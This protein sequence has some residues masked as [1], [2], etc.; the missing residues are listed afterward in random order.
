[1]TEL[2]QLNSRKLH[3]Q[4]MAIFFV[5]YIA[6]AVS[7]T[8]MLPFLSD[9]GY[10]SS[11]KGLIL[12]GAAVISIIGQFLFGF[13]CDKYKT[14]KK[15]FYLATIVFILIVTWAYSVTEIAF[16]FHLITLSL[17]GGF[18]RIVVGL[19]DS[20]TIERDPL[21]Q[22]NYGII[23][24]FG[25]LGWIIGAPYTVWA[26]SKGGYGSIGLNVGILSI[27]TL[28]IGATMGDAQKVSHQAPIKMVDIK[29]LLKKKQY[30]ILLI[31]L[32]LINIV[33]YADAYTIVNKILALGGTATDISNKW[34]LQAFMEL[35]LFFLGSVLYK[36]FSAKTLLMVGIFMFMV[37]F[38][39]SA[40][41]TSA[42]QLV[43][44]S[45]TQ[46]VT[47]PF[48]LLSSKQLIDSES[49]AHLKS[50]G[51]LLGLAMY[52]GLS[53][54]ISPLMSGFLVDWI[55]TDQTLIFFGLLCLVPLG[56]SLWYRKMKAAY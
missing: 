51:Q 50:T 34:V 38:L 30:I 1:M 17:M 54:L 8:Q 36:R 11:E 56:L 42:A 5:A 4:F 49:P 6:Y 28:L 2:K 9:I 44:I 20:W 18:F 52:S 32:T 25:S 39:L 46:L 24:A 23:R 41:A 29:Q 21:L 19:L 48:I 10:T 35:P 15:M 40:L 33:L 43:M 55:G 16:F 22:R 31:I 14:V 7:Y 13:L 3:I 12:S 37:R 26:L 45:A 47:F 53:A 27:L